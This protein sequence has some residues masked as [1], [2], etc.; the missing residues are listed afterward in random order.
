MA[1]T[2]VQGN[3]GY[4]G[5]YVQNPTLAYT[6]QN[7]TSGDLLFTTVWW[8]FN[9]LGI[10]NLT[11]NLGDSVPW[12]AVGTPITDGAVFQSQMYTK[13]AGATGPCTVTVN[14]IDANTNF[15]CMALGEYNGLPVGAAL[16][17]YSPNSSQHTANPIS[18]SI[19]TDAGDL[20]LAFI[21][22][23]HDVGATGAVAPFVYEEYVSGYGAAIEDYISPGGALTASFNPGYVDYDAVGIVSFGSVTYTI[24]GT[25]LDG[26]SNPVVGATVNCTGQAPTTTAS[27]GTYSFAGLVGGSYTVTP[28][29][30]GWSFAPTNRVVVISGGNQSGVNFTGTHLQ[31][32]TPMYSP[33]G[34]VYGS[35]TTVTVTDTDSGLSGFAMY[36][37]LDGSIPTTGSTLYT[38]P[39]VISATQTLKVLAVATGYLN[40]AVQSA[41]YT[42]SSGGE[43][44]SDGTG[45]TSTSGADTTPEINSKKTSVMGS[46][47]TGIIG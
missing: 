1:F 44:P 38:V 45:P 21:A 43:L 27:D 11:D 41:T 10:T 31:V 40:S 18:N 7:V 22:M 12:V 24:S 37:T 29:E 14:F 8:A 19:P 26:S 30:T 25:I 35:P 3:K 28:T 33:A 32:A 16:K 34:G 39:I 6:T 5:R 20:V 15:V 2:W 17:Q 23:A 42:I 9:D 4:V 36:Y 47:R 46:R 13:I